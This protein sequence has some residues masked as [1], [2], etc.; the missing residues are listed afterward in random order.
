MSTVGAASS[1][2]PTTP[3]DA[4]VKWEGFAELG[5]YRSMGV[6]FVSRGH[7]AGRWRAE[8]SVNA[9]GSAVYAS[10]SRSSHFPVGAVIAKKHLERDA[11]TLGPL[12]VM[13]KR[14][15]GFFPQGG[16]WE[17]LV[18]DKDGWIEDRGPLATCARCHVEANADWVF[19]LPA[20]ARAPAP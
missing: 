20:E 7:F 2:S 5:G 17:Y 15:P 13:I 11:G 10:L 4:E 6:P 16:D 1:G 12:F 14:A 8:V 9:A 19:G 18:T 3:R